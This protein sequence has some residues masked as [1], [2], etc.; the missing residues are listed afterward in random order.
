MIKRFSRCVA[1]FA[2]CVAVTFRHGVKKFARRYKA[3]LHKC[4][5]EGV[6][7]LV[8]ASFLSGGATMAWS[9]GQHELSNPSQFGVLLMVLGIAGLLGLGTRSPWLRTGFA[10]FGLMV[11]VKM[12]LL[13]AARDFYDPAWVSF[14]ISALA[15]FWIMVRVMCYEAKNRRAWMDFLAP[16]N[17]EDNV[18]TQ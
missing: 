9:D 2:A 11:R 17:E 15:L 6:E 1:A 8:A 7:L 10:F 16:V 3:I 12:A 4:P 18:V 5:T 13:Y 14:A